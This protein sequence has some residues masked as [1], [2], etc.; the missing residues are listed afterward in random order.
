MKTYAEHVP[1]PFDHHLALEDREDWLLV[2][3]SQTRDSGAFDKANFQAALEILGD[4]SETVE[5]HRFGH[6]GP[7]WYEIIL[8]HPSRL[9]EVEEIAA[10][11]EQYP[12][13]NDEKL[14][15]LER[16]E[17]DEAWKFWINSDL[18]RKLPE[19][20][21]NALD[22]VGTFDC[23][24]EE[25]YA[26]AKEDENEYGYNED[27]GFYIDIDKLSGAYAKRLAEKLDVQECSCTT[28]EF[29][30]DYDCEDCGNRF[31]VNRRGAARTAVKGGLK[32]GIHTKP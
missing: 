7:G 17:E 4:E 2:P 3:V 21:D 32:N 20:L 11:L 28:E 29:D 26:L 13:L 6:W 12:V 1:T 16:E 30:Q 22:D 24:E 8:V 15:E 31:W 27:S 25:A 9:A 23:P 5:V 10:S 14:S 18:N 19:W